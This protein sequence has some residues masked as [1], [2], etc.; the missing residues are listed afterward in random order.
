MIDVSHKQARFLIS[1]AMDGKLPKEQWDILQSHLE[2][3]EECNIYRDQCHQLEKSLRKVLLSRWRNVNGPMPGL[4]DGILTW[5]DTRKLRL[6]HL[7]YSGFGILV[8]LVII[9]LVLT[10]Q[11]NKPLPPAL[12]PKSTPAEHFQGVVTFTVNKNGRNQIFL[13]NSGTG[14]Q[15]GDQTTLTAGTSDNIYPTWS[16]DGDWIAFLSNRGG[17]WQLYVMNVAGTHL[18]QLTDDP[19]IEWNGPLSWS[20]DGKWIALTGKRLQQGN[21]SWIYLV[22]SSGPKGRR[23]DFPDPRALAQTRGTT[24]WARFSPYRPWLAVQLANGGIQIYSL[25]DN[26]AGEITESERQTQNMRPAPGGDFDWSSDTFSLVYLSQGP[27]NRT[28]PDLAQPDA[29]TEIVTTLPI[30]PYANLQGLSRRRSVIYSLSG[31]NIL[32]SVSY[33]PSPPWGEFIASLRDV[34]G[35]GCW[36]VFLTNLALKETHP[37]ELPDL[38]IVSPLE[39]ANWSSDGKWLVVVARQRNPTASVPVGETAMYAIRI[40][41][42]IDQ[43]PILQFEPLKNIPSGVVSVAVRPS[44]NSLDIQPMAASPEP[45]S[46]APTPPANLPGQVIYSVSVPIQ[47]SE[48]P[49]SAIYKINPDGTG[50]RLLINHATTNLC[51]TWSPDRKFIAF[52]SDRDI[53]DRGILSDQNQDENGLIPNQVYIMDADGKTLTRLNAMRL[54][55]GVNIS[56]IYDCPIWSPDS[57]LLT[58]LSHSGQSFW[59]NFFTQDGVSLNISNI[60]H[61]L[62]TANPV[63]KSKGEM[64]ILTEPAFPDHRAFITEFAY[65]SPSGINPVL[66]LDPGWDDVQAISFSPDDWSLALV[67]VKY[68]DGNHKGEAKLE[69]YNWRASPVFRKVVDITLP[70]YDPAAIQFPGR[71]EWMEDGDVVLAIPSGPTARYKATLVRYNFSK[72]SLTPFALIEDTLYGWSIQPGWIIFG[73]ESGLWGMPVLDQNSQ[74]SK[75]L[76]LDNEI[77]SSLDW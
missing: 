76:Q 67:L 52:L 66:E 75:P 8:S 13:L 56:P 25:E 36:N 21:T 10:A 61:T 17:S 31:V 12:T 6:Q 28:Q 1:M 29:K 64:V 45:S 41:K 33:A 20:F 24:G 38:C 70:D 34:S 23:E 42:A 68:A 32:H 2:K 74:Q 72:N 19:S 63:W 69:I 15:S 39:H 77:V 44:G 37:L 46:S 51:P 26:T 50:K 11:T 58:A 47:G 9:Y 16:P 14:S 35:T 27:Y 62:R 30:Q 53:P 22:Q 54:P 49:N 48:L 57:Q 60:D 40:P 18:T 4:G 71:I 5:R 3:C 73:T 7:M 59:L 55:P 65:D 43:S